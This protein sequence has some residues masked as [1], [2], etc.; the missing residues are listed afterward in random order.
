MKLLNHKRSGNK[1]SKLTKQ[2]KS[3]ARKQSKN[4]IHLNSLK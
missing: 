3:E 1:A 2:E 4:F